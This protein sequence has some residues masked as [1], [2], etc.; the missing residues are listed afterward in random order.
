MV[1]LEINELIDIVLLGESSRKSFL[2]KVDALS[3]VI[4]CANVEGMA[5]AEDVGE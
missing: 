1:W 5:I 4:Y 3:Q 2:M